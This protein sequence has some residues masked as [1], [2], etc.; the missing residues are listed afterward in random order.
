MDLMSNRLNTGLI[1]FDVL[2]KSVQKLT[3]AALVRDMVL[4][5]N[6]VIDLYQVHTD[7]ISKGTG[8]HIV[9]VHIP[10]FQPAT[11]LTL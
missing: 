6:E 4:A 3:E 11:S 10:M 2:D 1:S 7:F 5:I 8:R 9:M